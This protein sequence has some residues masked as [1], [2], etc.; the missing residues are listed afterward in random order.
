MDKNKNI[1]KIS[2]EANRESFELRKLLLTLAT[3]SLVLS[4][5]FLKDL[6]SQPK[7][8]WI[9]VLVWLALVISIGAGIFHKKSYMISVRDAYL[10]KTGRMKFS[11]KRTEDFGKKME[12]YENWQ[13]WTFFAGIFLL[14]I[15]GVINLYS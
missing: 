7:Q 3:G 12:K 15:F 14:F 2:A 10:I 6:I 4:I 9:I 11:L 13:L 5:T 1:K 8:G